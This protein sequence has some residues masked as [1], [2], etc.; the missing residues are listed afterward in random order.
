MLAIILLVFIYK[1]FAWLAG[2]HNKKKWPI[3]LLGIA[4]YYFGTLIGALSILLYQE[5]F[6]DSY[7]DM[8]DISFTLLPI[9]FGILTSAILYKILKRFWAKKAEFADV[10]I[11]DGELIDR[12]PDEL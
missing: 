1:A 7:Y 12:T 11:V 3:G 9:P 5:Y 10:D 8:S 4:V 2:Q 6:S